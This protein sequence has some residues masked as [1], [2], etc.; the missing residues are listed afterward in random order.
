MEFSFSDA[1]DFVQDAADT[2]LQAVDATA[3]AMA[4]TA[5]KKVIQKSPRR[6]KPYAGKR[7]SR[8]LGR[9]AKGWKKAI[10]TAYGIKQRIVRNTAEPG[11]THILEKGTKERATKKGYP[12]GR[13]LPQPHIRAAFDETV[14]EF[15]N[16]N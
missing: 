12:R 2:E 6:M 4:E 14:A 13:V 8:K 1:M 5:L 9:Y 10:E 11:L 3:D 7:K 15:E 16:K